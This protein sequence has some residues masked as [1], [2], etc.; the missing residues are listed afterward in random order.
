MA[1]KEENH[2]EGWH[3]YKAHVKIRWNKSI[4]HTLPHIEY[5]AIATAPDTAVAKV[6]P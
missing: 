2:A 1:G 3:N 5:F 4:S 6:L